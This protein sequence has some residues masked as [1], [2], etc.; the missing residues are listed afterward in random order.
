MCAE[1]CAVYIYIYFSCLFNLNI[2]THHEIR[3]HYFTLLKDTREHV[4][5]ITYVF[6]IPCTNVNNVTTHEFVR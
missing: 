2:F 4:V 6:E 1:E 3:I 5:Y